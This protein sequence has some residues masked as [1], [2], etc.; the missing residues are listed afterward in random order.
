MNILVFNMK[1]SIAKAVFLKATLPFN[2]TTIIH[3]NY[4]ECVYENINI[5]SKIDRF[6]Y[7]NIENIINYV[8]VNNINIL[9]CGAASFERNVV[10]ELK[11]KCLLIEF[12]KKNEAIEMISDFTVKYEASTITQK[13]LLLSENILNS[14]VILSHNIGGGLSKYV[15]DL[16]RFK[17]HLHYDYEHFEYVSNQDGENKQKYKYYDN[18][19]IVI[20]LTENNFNNLIIHLNG[21]LYNYSKI[22][23]ILN[24]VK[25]TNLKIIITIHDFYWMFEKD[26]NII[27][28]SWNN[29]IFDN[30]VINIFN[31]SNIIIFPSQNVLNIY[32][33]ILTNSAT[34]SLHDPSTF[35]NIKNKFTLSKHIDLYY[36]NVERYIQQYN[37]E[38]NIAFLGRS[39][40]IK[41]F[42]NLQI[43]VNCL[44]NS[45][46][47]INIYVLGNIYK[48]L[49]NLNNNVKIIYINDYVESE[50]PKIINNIK[51]HLF[52]L[53]SNFLE[54]YS[55]VTSFVFYTG[56]PIFCYY[57]VYNFRIN[58]L[59]NKDNIYYYY[60]KVDIV[61]NFMVCLNDLMTNISNVKNFSDVILNY[62][63]DYYVPMFYEN[64]YGKIIE[65][66]RLENIVYPS[67]NTTDS[68]STN[69]N[70]FAIYFPQFHRIKENDINHYKN[71]T[72]F[73]NMKKIPAKSISS[74][75]IKT[76]L[77]GNY[78]LLAEENILDLQIKTAKN[79][80]I[81]GFGVY[82]YWFDINTQTENN[83]VMKH[84][85][86]KFLN[87]NDDFNYFFIWANEKWND[88]MY[89]LNIINKE[90]WNNHFNYLLTHF[91]NKNYLKINDRPVFYILHYWLFNEEILIEMINF[92]NN[93]LSD[94]GFSGIHLG[95]CLN[96][97]IPV[98]KNIV[99]D[100]YINTPAWKKANKFGLIFRSDKECTV[101]YNHYLEEFETE[102]IQEKG[103][104]ISD[105]IV[106]NLF[107][108]FNN[109][110]RNYCKKTNIMTYKYINDTNDNF[111]KYL[112]KIK[113]L[114][115]IYTNQNNMLLINAWNEWGENMSI[116]PSN[117][118]KFFYLEKINEFL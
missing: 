31:K 79:Y 62:T 67:L 101:D 84:V 110:V 93:K 70:I 24:N 26:P 52:L 96:F 94:H 17:E 2:S 80:N 9:L 75:N 3:D 115:T 29:R 104:D 12:R 22:S 6:K 102:L 59:I 108:G 4:S 27:Y 71:Y 46:Y 41:G 88:E 13:P 7:E 90:L 97:D 72:D 18:N 114:T 89:N 92:F 103:H 69:L 78:D 20:Y 100:Y 107:P 117:E 35:N 5:E 95:M 116:E 32:K 76:P 105:K 91:K 65:N 42:D 64:L 87:I 44:E 66:A 14:V 10:N 81:K 61:S 51:P 28:P 118:S 73:N 43:I 60:S 49:K 11:N 57:N 74:L 48:T 77:F 36:Y 113:K 47:N 38:F 85:S 34:K 83:C 109:Y 21:N 37:N 23:Q 40:N 106:L 99:C 68:K 19:E 58:S 25:A 15:N 56:L 30:N 53:L 54:T 111:I 98:Y 50:L 1:Q 39:D 86:D 55:Y 45:N 16:L 33:E 63:D 112:K 8:A 82:H